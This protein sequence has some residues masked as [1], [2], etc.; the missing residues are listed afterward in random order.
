M[1]I[2]YVDGAIVR[3]VNIGA[4]WH[5]VMYNSR[6]ENVHIKQYTIVD[7]LVVQNGTFGIM[8]ADALL[9]IGMNVVQGQI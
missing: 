3:H 8:A 6:V 7:C 5:I 9:S 2:L 1:S 4:L